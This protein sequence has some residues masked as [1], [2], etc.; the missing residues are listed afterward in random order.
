MRQ[1]IEYT[2]LIS[3]LSHQQQRGDRSMTSTPFLI[4][5]GAS[6]V[7]TPVF[8][9]IFLILLIFLLLILFRTTSKRCPSC[10]KAIK[11]GDPFCFG[12]GLRLSGPCP[13]CR[14]PL[15][16]K[17]IFCSR[18][19]YHLSAPPPQPSPLTPTPTGPNTPTPLST[20]TTISTAS[21]PLTVLT[22]FSRLICPNCRA[23]TQ[24]NDSF[25]GSCGYAL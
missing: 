10:K 8:L 1:E 3:S 6:I 19:G 16:G 18:C 2:A 4:I 9:F 20:A 24:A 25:C 5:I 17:G 15:N 13:A 23:K 14:N 21:F 7:I 12:C 22:Q 11:K